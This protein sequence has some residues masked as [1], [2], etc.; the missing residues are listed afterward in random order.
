MATAIINVLGP[1]VGSL[2]DVGY[3]QLGWRNNT[4]LFIG[5]NFY[6]VDRLASISLTL[7]TTV[8][9]LDILRPGRGKRPSSKAQTEKYSPHLCCALT[10]IKIFY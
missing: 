7:T 8:D 1:V 10:V 9:A 5:T 3:G 4:K 2:D 6:L